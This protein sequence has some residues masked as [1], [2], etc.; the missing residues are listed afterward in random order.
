[1]K[2]T[3]LSPTGE[4]SDKHKINNTDHTAGDINTEKLPSVSGKNVEALHASPG[5]RKPA[6][7][8]INFPE[9]IAPVVNND[10]LHHFSS[11]GIPLQ[12][13]LHDSIPP[14]LGK[15]SDFLATKR[16]KFTYQISM[17][18]IPIGNAELEA[19]N[20]NGEIRITLRVKSNAAISSVYPV[21]NIVETRHISGKFIM[22]KIRQQEGSF[23]SDEYF[24]INLGKRRVSWGD[25]ISGR[26][27][28]LSV[29]TENVLDTLSGMYLLR[30]R[31]LQVGTTE[32][33]HIFDS[34]T[35]SDVPV[36]VLRREKILLPNFTEVETVVVQPLQKSAGIF[37]RT[38]DL[39]I[40]LT[41]DN[42][43]VPV[44]IVT[45]VPPGKVTAELVSSESESAETDSAESR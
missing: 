21:D 29:P 41:D 23:K 39:L 26:N 27:L 35:Y 20:E 22:T 15:S 24:T 5:Q 14:P 33:L 8:Q 4:K 17:L 13:P 36:D 2:R 44:K 28:T 19:K 16:E 25:N 38:G 12:Q 31:Q 42:Y 7:E 6:Q 32:I 9:K 45:T 1:M 43:K 34:E 11:P 37:R 30:N 40:W 10:V 18:G 3:D